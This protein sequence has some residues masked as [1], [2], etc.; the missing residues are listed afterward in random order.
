MNNEARKILGIHHVTAITG[1]AQ[2]N[3]DFYAGILGMRL[4]KLT[5]NFDDP[6]AYHLYY[7]NDVGRPGTI[8]TFF[9][10]PRAGQGRQ[11]T[12]QATAVSLSIPQGSMGYWMD[13]LKEYD[14]TTEGPFDRFDEEVICFCDPDGLQLELVEHAATEKRNGWL[15]G[16]VLDHHVLRGIC[17]VTIAEQAF[18]LTARMMIEVLGFRCVKRAGSLFRFEM[19]R[20]GPGARIDLQYNPDRSR[21]LVACGTVH[22]V[23][24]RTTD[25][26]EHRAWRGIL[27]ENKVNVT[28]IIDRRYFHSIYFREPGGVLFEIAT[29]GPGFTIDEA[30]DR[31]GTSLVLPPWLEKNRSRIEKTVRPLNLKREFQRA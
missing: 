21:G 7:G 22:H 15:K 5:V 25:N 18:A 17:G 11:G 20:G 2:Q 23:A 10:W 8:L 6:S 3:L 27:V 24:W 16:P 12:A 19:G 1:D 31:L 4:V 14:V 9:A 13:R 29:D 30:A 26:E 28:P